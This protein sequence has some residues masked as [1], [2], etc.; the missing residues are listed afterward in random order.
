MPAYKNSS[1][2]SGI[3]SYSIGNNFIKIVFRDGEEYLYTKRSAG[4]RHLKNMKKLAEAGKGLT[5]YINQYVKEK[6]EK[7]F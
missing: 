3:L 1:G 7:K 4:I 2:N 6:F 5:T